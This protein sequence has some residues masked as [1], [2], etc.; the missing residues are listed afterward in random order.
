MGGA[1]GWGEGGDWGE[2]GVLISSNAQDQKRA[3]ISILL[4]TEAPAFCILLLD[5]LSTTADISALGISL[6]LRYNHSVFRNFIQAR[7]PEAEI[8]SSQ[9]TQNDT[10]LFADFQLL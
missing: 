2:A 1:A 7:I 4:A 5:W 8:R 6:L 9:K 3:R 10:L